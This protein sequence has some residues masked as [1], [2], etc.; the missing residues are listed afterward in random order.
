MCAPASTASADFVGN[1]VHVSTKNLVDTSILKRSAAI[2]MPRQDAYNTL[3]DAHVI[4][5]TVRRA[6][7]WRART[8]RWLTSDAVEVPERPLS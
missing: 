4:A 8:I 2:K 3:A 1:S 5:D 6:D 7:G